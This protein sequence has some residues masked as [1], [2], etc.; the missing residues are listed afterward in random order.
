MVI[1]SHVIQKIKRFCKKKIKFFLKNDRQ[2]KKPKKRVEKESGQVGR[3]GEKNVFSDKIVG[4][5]TKKNLTNL[6][7]CATIGML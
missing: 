6:R 3:R 4:I 7:I 5:P 1:I 2:R